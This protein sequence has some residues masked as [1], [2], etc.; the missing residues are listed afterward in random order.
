MY[1]ADSEKERLKALCAYENELYGKG[2]SF[3][4]GIDE[5]G[6]GSLA[7]C[8]VACAVILPAG[9]TYAG[10]NDSKKVSP[11]RREAL[12][13]ILREK[14]V[15]VGI[16]AIDAETIDNVNILQATILAMCAA[17]ANL[18]LTPEYLLIDALKLPLDIP[19][20]PITGGDAKSISIAS[21]S[22]VAKVYRDNLMRELDK[23]YPEYG[24]AQNK[25]YGTAAH[26]EA[27]KKHGLCPV[28]RRSFN[29]KK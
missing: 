24:F 5:V 19:Q 20:T 21:A 18:D 29:V 25:G 11:K 28:H 6:R 27:I 8:V 7:G 13:E 10:I 14:A 17:V 12:S 26:I 22:I 16:G 9:F 4:A 3:L 1:A 23:L 15:S 2:Y